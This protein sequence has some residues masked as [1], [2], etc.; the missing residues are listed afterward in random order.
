MSAL[1]RAAPKRH[2]RAC[3]EEVHQ[4]APSGIS[5]VSG[6]LSGGHFCWR[7]YGHDEGQG[8]LGNV[9]YGEYICLCACLRPNEDGTATVPA[10]PDSRPISKSFIPSVC[11]RVLCTTNVLC[12]RIVDMLSIS[13]LVSSHCELL[14]ELPTLCI[15]MAP[16]HCFFK[17]FAVK[18]LPCHLSAQAVSRIVSIYSTP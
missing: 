14:G 15:S 8:E 2:D 9:H 11:G 17:L 13:P 7:G 18:P 5:K 6:L 10:S 4:A 16:L 1:N 3:G 12:L